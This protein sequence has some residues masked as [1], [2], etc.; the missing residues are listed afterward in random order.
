[1][2]AVFIGGATVYIGGVV[3]DAHI[4]VTTVFNCGALGL[5]LCGAL[6]WSVKPKAP[7][8]TPPSP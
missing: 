6:L 5:L 8:S 4:P 3:R 1:M 7:E 2:L